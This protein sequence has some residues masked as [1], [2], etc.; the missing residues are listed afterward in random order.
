MKTDTISKE[1]AL[2]ELESFINKW[3]KRPVA[4]SKLEKTYPDV[5]DAIIDG[6]LSI[7]DEGMPSY[8][9][10][11]PLKNDEGNVTVSEIT[12]FRT[13]IKP[14]TLADLAKGLHPTEEVFQLQLNM[15]AY[16]LN[17]PVAMIDKFERYDYDALNQIASVFS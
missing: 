17:Q 14:S 13:R 12:G 15:T 8:K 11:F 9:L 3:V 5:L 6:F 16:I 4:K 2:D 1:V 10:K 7:D